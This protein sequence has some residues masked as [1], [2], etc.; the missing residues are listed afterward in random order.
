MTVAAM[1]L[2]NGRSSL[3]CRKNPGGRGGKK[4]TNVWQSS[5]YVTQETNPA[6]DKNFRGLRTDTLAHGSAVG[7][8]EEEFHF[9]NKQSALDCQEIQ[10]QRQ[11]VRARPP[12]NAIGYW[13]LRVIG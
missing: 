1:M 4:T 6:T 7:I 8:S 12:R 3:G 11:H 2:A 10:A 13:V 9:D 5:T